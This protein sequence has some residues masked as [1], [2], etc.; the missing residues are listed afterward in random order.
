MVKVIL[1]NLIMVYS[2]VLF[3]C[4]E[5]LAEKGF[6]QK[7]GKSMDSLRIHYSL[8]LTDSQFYVSDYGQDFVF[9]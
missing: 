3:S 8:P 4:R 7:Y 5:G 1:L 2:L 6:Y 9:F